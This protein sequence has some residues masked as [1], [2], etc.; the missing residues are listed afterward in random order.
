[1]AHRDRSQGFGFVYVDIKK[2]LEE[3][4]ALGNPESPTPVSTE[5]VA[6]ANFPKTADAVRE[7]SQA[8]H[9]IKDNLDRLQSLHHRLHAMLAEI[10]QITD[11]KKKP[12]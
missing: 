1:M 7:R 10:G 5:G 4:D 3:K 6:A 9:Q 8:V 11:K 12:N 2:L